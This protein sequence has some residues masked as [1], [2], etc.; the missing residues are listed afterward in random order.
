V[1]AAVSIVLPTRN[2]G[3]RL[4]SV[5]DALRRQ[6]HTAP[7]EIVVVDSGSTDGT[8]ALAKQ[9]A[10][11]VISVDPRQFNHGATRNLGIERAQGKFVILLV[12]DAVPV[13]DDW[14][15]TLVEPLNR[16]ERLAGTFGRQVPEPIASP[17]TRHYLSLWRAAG[18]EPRVV[19]VGSQQEFKGLPPEERFDRCIIDNVCACI[20]RDVWTRFP[21]LT[22]PIAED[23]AWG[24]D[25]LLAGF[26]LAYVP[27]AAVEHSHERSAR[28]EL[29]RTWVLHQQLY[30]LFGLRTIPTL[31][32]LGRAVASS[33]RLHHRL[34][35][36]HQADL[37]AQL[38]G[39]RLA[40][41]WPLG[42][43]MGGWTAAHG[44]DWHPRG[45]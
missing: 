11:V 31:G 4:Q 15:A 23:L 43:Y 13:G 9:R 34:L 22:T 8:L 1:S 45:A 18:P 2:G 26:G 42:Q 25:V 33:L 41:A 16:N 28:Y 6:R 17:L 14:L 20:R 27:G 32:D 38:R 19:F 39:A 5:F 35:S 12:Q 30:E 21:F 36:E 10:D 40:I 44:R 37:R 7:L 3:A 24:R 29:T